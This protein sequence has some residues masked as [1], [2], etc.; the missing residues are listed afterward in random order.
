[1]RPRFR[2]Q[3]RVLRG[4]DGT[5]C[6]QATRSR[7]LLNCCAC[8]S[9]SGQHERAL[10]VAKQACTALLGTLGLPS[11]CAQLQAELRAGLAGGGAP[12]D[13]S[14]TAGAWTVKESA[15]VDALQARVTAQAAVAAHDAACEL[16]HLSRGQQ[17]GALRCAGSPRLLLNKSI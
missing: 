14:T 11:D 6:A 15:S 1:V 16:E 7:I 9:S 17:A 13:G 4:Q 10:R 5:V 2:L 12:A 8:L 3:S